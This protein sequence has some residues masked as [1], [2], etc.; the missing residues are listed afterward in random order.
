MDY[1]KNA[2]KEGYSQADINAGIAGLK[3]EETSKNMQLPFMQGMGIKAAIKEFKIPKISHVAYQGGVVC[4]GKAETF[5][6]GL[7]GLRAHYANGTREIY[8]ADDGLSITPV[9]AKLVEGE[10]I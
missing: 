5:T 9:A 3:W 6:A 1:F 2:E 7:Y 4:R 10:L 8:L